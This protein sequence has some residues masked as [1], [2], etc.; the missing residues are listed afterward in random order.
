VFSRSLKAIAGIRWLVVPRQ[1]VKVGELKSTPYKGDQSVQRIPE[2][3][4]QAATD[5]KNARD[6]NAFLHHNGVVS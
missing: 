3:R 4:T 2:L 6:L 1:H 5:T